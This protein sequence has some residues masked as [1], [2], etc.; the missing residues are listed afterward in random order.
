MSILNDPI[1]ESSIHSS[2]SFIFKINVSSD[3]HII[4]LPVCRRNTVPAGVAVDSPLAP[5][6]AA[7]A[8]L[9]KATDVPALPPV[10]SYWGAV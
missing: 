5:N 8:L 3:K 9:S 10:V 4:A 2:T 6:N 7:I 1:S